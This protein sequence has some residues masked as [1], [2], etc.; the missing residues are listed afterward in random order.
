MKPST[1]SPDFVATYHCSYR[2]PRDLALDLSFIA[3]SLGVSQSG[4]LVELL[5][6]PVTHLATLI[7]S[8]PPNPTPEDVVR[9]RGQSVAVLKDRVSQALAQVGELDS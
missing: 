4:L 6:D 8:V 3:K 9:L 7:R 2:L 5:T 1:T